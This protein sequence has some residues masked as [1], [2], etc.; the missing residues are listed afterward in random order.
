MINHHRRFRSHPRAHAFAKHLVQRGHKVT[1]ILIADQRKF[2]IVESQWDGVRIIETPDLLWGRLRS[3]WDLWELLNRVVYLNRDKGPYDLIH[4]FETRPAVIYPALFYQ[5]RHKIPIVTD[6]N[7][8]WGRG[9]II[10]EIRPGWFR[11]FFGGIETYYEEAFRTRGIGITVISTALAQRAGELGIAP[12]R[13]LH[14]PGGTFP[15][16]FQS[17]P[18]EEC[19]KRIGYPLSVPTLGFTS[20]DSHLDLE[21]VFQALEIVAKTHPTVKL[22][23]TGNPAP[24]ILR[25]AKARGLENN[26]FLTGF[27]PYEQLPWYLGCADMFVL[28]FPNKI[29][30]LGRWPNKICDYMS[31][32]RPTISSPVGDIKKL[33]E[34]SEVG[35]L[36][37]HDP[38]DFAEKIISLIEHPD[39]AEELGR[40]A[41][42]TALTRYDWKILISQLE[43]FYF[44]LLNVSPEAMPH[45]G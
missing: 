20:I 15:E 32:G 36:A 17:R 28:P 40:N 2:G 6:W 42:E 24:P 12:E 5:Y 29:Y 11:L 37:N 4:C 18:K 7:D 43:E 3:G 1:L 13:I 44:K 8:W 38:I 27:L 34:S 25:D 26:L 45:A 30:N 22:M 19:R 10:K 14:L 9:G 21:I 31:L 39:L 23:I 41:R 16:F 35:L 33:F